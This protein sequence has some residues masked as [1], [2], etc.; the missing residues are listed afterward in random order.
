MNKT[1]RLLPFLSCILA[2][3]AALAGAPPTD[4]RA[5]L[6]ETLATRP[7]VCN[8]TRLARE[9]F[10]PEALP[11]A[12]GLVPLL[13][14][15]DP[16]VR[17]AAVIALGSLGMID[18]T[19]AALA[20]PALTRLLRDKARSELHFDVLHALA[21]IGPRAAAA[22]ST[23]IE[24]Y[25]QSPLRLRLACCATLGAI[26]GASDKVVPALLQILASDP[27]PALRAAAI[28]NLGECGPAAQPAV[29][30]LQKLA[31]GDDPLLRPLTETALQRITAA[32]ETTAP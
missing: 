4:V 19:T 23:V 14:D 17:R 2:A 15:E 31:A 9:V 26:G 20:V 7:N 10:G 18:E 28:T 22:A 27:L 29:P 24:L 5:W 6:L 32:P 11:K 13:D 21:R 3:Q 16:K 30:T 12:P 8:D 1:T 25:P